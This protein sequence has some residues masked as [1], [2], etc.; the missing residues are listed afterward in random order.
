MEW[1]GGVNGVALYLTESAV[2]VICCCVSC[3]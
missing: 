2:V 1:L 3:F